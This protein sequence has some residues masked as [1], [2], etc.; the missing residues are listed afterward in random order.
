M[1]S[2]WFF[3]ISI[4]LMFYKLSIIIVVFN[5]TFVKFNIMVGGVVNIKTAVSS[6]L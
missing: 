3:F 4:N 1:G 2:P 6:L 5:N